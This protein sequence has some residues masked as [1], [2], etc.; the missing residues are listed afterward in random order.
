ME[1]N[2]KAEI[3]T[4]SVR[5]SK[6]MHEWY[7][8]EAERINVPFNAMIIFALLQYQ[9][10]QMVVPNLPGMMEAFQEHKKQNK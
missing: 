6:E 4:T 10:E 7:K 1:N 5:F 2:E 3:V 8:K 9:R